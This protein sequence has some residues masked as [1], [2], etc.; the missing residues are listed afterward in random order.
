MLRF[1]ERVCEHTS[2]RVATGHESRE[3]TSRRRTQSTSRVAESVCAADTETGRDIYKRHAETSRRA[4][5][6][7]DTQEKKEKKKKNLCMPEHH[8]SSTQKR[9]GDESADGRHLSQ[10]TLTL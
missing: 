4:R 7:A 10:E 8:D 2:S 1:A 6:A 9:K 5:A 3:P